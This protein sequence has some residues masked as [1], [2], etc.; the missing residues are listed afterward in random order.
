M[1]AD[2]AE[3][4]VKETNRIMAVCTELKKCGADITETDDGMIIRGG[5]KRTA[6]ILRAITT[7]EWQ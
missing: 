4:K 1:I 6:R 2:A 5:N 7:T 3:L